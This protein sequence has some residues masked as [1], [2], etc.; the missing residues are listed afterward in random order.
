MSR[1]LQ[2]PGEREETALVAACEQALGRARAAAQLSQWPEPGSYLAADMALLGLSQDQAGLEALF[3]LQNTD[4]GFPAYWGG[5][6]HVDTSARVWAA[7]R[8]S[9]MSGDRVSKAAAA[10]KAMG[11]LDELADETRVEWALLGLIPAD[12]VAAESSPAASVLHGMVRAGGVVRQIGLGEIGGPGAAVTQGKGGLREWWARTG[13]VGARKKALTRILDEL[14]QQAQTGTVLDPRVRA[15]WLAAVYVGRQV[16][17]PQPG[18][19]VD[20][21]ESCAHGIEATL[22]AQEADGSWR[23]DEGF[24]HG[25]WQALQALR[26]AG[27]DD[28]EAEVLRAG[29]WLR[30]TQNADGGWGEAGA[31]NVSHA[32][33]A[34]MGLI[35]GGDAASESATKGL[36]YLLAAQSTE[37]LWHERA[38]TRTVCPRLAYARDEARAQADS[39]HAIEEFAR[40]ATGTRG[41]NG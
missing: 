11:G 23:D 9:G 2:I 17:A 19:R 7:M 33:W 25:T 28:H 30:S 14:E 34:L 21:A 6:S 32:A 16:I 3:G 36:E 27:F 29:E 35:A 38:W 26:A 4:G 39:A 24:I 40:V 10:V 8:L 37:G 5:P 1:R 13:G 41:T 12:R 18:M 31:S 22:R 20:H 15:A